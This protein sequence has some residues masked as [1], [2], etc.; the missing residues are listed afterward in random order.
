MAYMTATKESL[1]KCY[2]SICSA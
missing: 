1:R 2:D